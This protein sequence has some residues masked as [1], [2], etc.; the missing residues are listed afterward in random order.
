MHR[1]HFRLGF[2]SS[3]YSGSGFLCPNLQVCSRPAGV[4][5]TQD[6]L[7]RVGADLTLSATLLPFLEAYAGMHSHATSDNFGRPQLLQVLGD[8]NLGL[9]GFLSFPDDAESDRN[10][11]LACWIGKLYNKRICQCAWRTTDES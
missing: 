3:Y 9:K 2:L 6:T 11:A 1:A 7:D 10:P 5:D 8:T 4:T